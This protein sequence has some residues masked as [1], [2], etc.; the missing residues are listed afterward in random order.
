MKYVYPAIFYKEK[1]GGYSVVFPDIPGGTQGET[2]CEAMEMAESFLNFAIV[3]SGDDEKI[4]EPTPIENVVPEKFD[5][6]DGAFVTLI[7][8]D[9][10]E[11]R[12]KTSAKTIKEA[13]RKAGR[14]I[15]ETAEILGAPYRTVQNWFDGTRK[16]PEWVERLVIEKLENFAG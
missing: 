3:S 13:A 6:V 10:S 7:K 8:V 2:L 15:K 14:N 5:S 16:P 4:S 9:T 12:E 1:L 11:Y